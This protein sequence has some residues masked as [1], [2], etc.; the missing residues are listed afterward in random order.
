MSSALRALRTRL[1]KLSSAMNALPGQTHTVVQR[2][3][4]GETVGQ[5]IER[6][7]LGPVAPQD[8]VIVIRR[9]A[10]G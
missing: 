5:A 8:L 3:G 9:F 1:D 6:A 4:M 7:N 10:H 2:D